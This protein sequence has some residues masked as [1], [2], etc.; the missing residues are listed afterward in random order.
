MTPFWGHCKVFLGS[1]VFCLYWLVSAVISADRGELSLLLSCCD[2]LLDLVGLFF[3]LTKQRLLFAVSNYCL[4]LCSA[5]SF[6]IEPLYC[7]LS[8]KL[9]FFDLFQLCSYARN[10]SG[11]M[12]FALAEYLRFEAL[13]AF[14]LDLTGHF[15]FR[16]FRFR[17]SLARI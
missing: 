11:R 6:F 12:F 14:A 5:E 15:D 2:F 8:F 17:A 4:D 10:L 16:R 13:S 1:I 3:D 9:S 7:Q